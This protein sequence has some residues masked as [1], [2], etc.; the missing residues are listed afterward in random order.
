MYFN[1]IDNDG[2]NISV[3]LSKLRE[4]KKNFVDYMLNIISFTNKYR[5]YTIYERQNAF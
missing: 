3:K 1:E 5:R 2:N 4:L